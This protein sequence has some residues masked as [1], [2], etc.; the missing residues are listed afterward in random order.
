MLLYQ[1][2]EA[3]LF[4]LFTGEPKDD[5][6]LTQCFA[7]VRSNKDLGNVQQFLTDDLNH[8]VIRPEPWRKA[9]SQLIT[10][11]ELG[12][13]TYSLEDV[14][15]AYSRPDPSPKLFPQKMSQDKM[16]GPEGAYTIDG[17]LYLYSLMKDERSLRL[18]TPDGKKE[19]RVLRDDAP[20]RLAWAL[21][22][23][24]RDIQHVPEKDELI[25]PDRMTEIESEGGINGTVSMI[26]WNYKKGTLTRLD[27]PIIDLFKRS[28]GQLLPRSPIAVK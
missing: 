20:N 19:F 12:G 17:N 14:G 4:D 2:G 3:K 27:T 1:E 26:R 15:L 8:L 24:F 11:F 13:K 10:T 21:S 16:E 5:P 23:P 28:R 18:Y 7:Q 22:A 6:W 9:R 25:I